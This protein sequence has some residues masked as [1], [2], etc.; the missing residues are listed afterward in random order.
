MSI[1]DSP[2]EDI[3]LIKVA[4][5]AINRR[6]D[7]YEAMMQGALKIDTILDQN[8]MGLC[9]IIKYHI[10]GDKTDERESG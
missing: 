9:D 5:K 10:F 2:A 8:I 1:K 6:M 7:H 3:E 4:I